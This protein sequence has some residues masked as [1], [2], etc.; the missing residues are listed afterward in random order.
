MYFNCGDPALGIS[1]CPQSTLIKQEFI[2]SCSSPPKM[3][4]Y[5]WDVAAT[6]ADL[7]MALALDQDMNAV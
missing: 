7:V 2:W 6:M 3:E 4:A 1:K 5:V